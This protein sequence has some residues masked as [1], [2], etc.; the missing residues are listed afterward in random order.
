ML[1]T[2]FMSALVNL[3]AQVSFQFLPAINGQSVNGLYMAQLQNTGAAS[4]YGRTQITVK[5][6]G[7]KT[8]LVILTPAMQVKPGNNLLMA[9][10]PQ[11]HIQFG[12]S[13]AAGVTSQ[14]GRLP[15]GGYEY[16]FEFAGTENKTTAEQVFE[17]C[18]NHLIQP[19]IPLALVY[20][21]DRDQICSTRPDLSWQPG[22]PL[23][24]QL[25]YRLILTER[26]VN[27]QGADALMNNV[28]ALQQDNIAGCMLLYPAQA[29]PLQ[30]DKDYAWQV[31]AYL[32]NTKM[33]Q[34]EIGEFSIK[35]DDRKIDSSRE[36]YRQPGTSLNGN[37][38]IT[39]TILRFTITNAYNT[40][41]MDYSITD[42]ADPTKKIS[43]LPAVKIQ[44]GLSRVDI[45]LEDIRGLVLHKI[46]LLKI[47]NIGNQPLYL[48]FIYK[49]DAL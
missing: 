19:T 36:S 17:N 13:A 26:K 43:N 10:M 40:Q 3:S 31:V 39:G 47:N 33:S 1:L 45:P 2:L 11:S 48:R 38:Y 37:Y 29:A 27:Q 42:L 9:L 5:D 7:N 25:R 32:G 30:K 21:A 49:A 34:S 15:E 16:C 4:Y 12:N 44:T 35:C 46:Y 28:P 24:S 20:P 6:E 14:T 41:N 18:F 23:N 8:V 22:M